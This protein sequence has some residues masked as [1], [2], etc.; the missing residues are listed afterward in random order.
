LDDVFQF[1][2]ADFCLACNGHAVQTVPHYGFDLRGRKIRAL[3]QHCWKLSLVLHGKCGGA[4]QSATAKHHIPGRHGSVARRTPFIEDGFSVCL[5]SRLRQ[6]GTA[7][8]NDQKEKEH[9]S[10]TRFFLIFAGQIP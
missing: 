4:G 1:R 5:R 3:F 6:R 10:H 7:R 8:A 9:R 2:I